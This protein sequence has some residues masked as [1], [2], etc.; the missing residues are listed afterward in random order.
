MDRFSDFKL[1]MG[2]VGLIK[3]EKDWRGVGRPQVAM[4]SQLP[5]FLVYLLTYLLSKLASRDL[6][7]VQRLCYHSYPLHLSL[8]QWRSCS[9]VTT[10]RNV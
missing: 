4:H 6:L 3:A 9:Q 1:V 5:R 2:V 8:T 10:E 7:C